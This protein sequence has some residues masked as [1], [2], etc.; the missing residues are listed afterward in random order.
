MGKHFALVAGAVMAG[1]TGAAQ[2][3]PVARV[4]GG[5][6]AGK[7]LP[8]VEAFLGIP[9]AAPPVG[10]SRWRAPQ[11]VLPWQGKRDATRFGPACAQGIAGAW[12]PYSAEFIAQP[13]VS[14]DCLTLNV[15]KPVKSN[16]KLPVFVYIHGGAFQGGAGSLPVYDGSALAARGAVVITI[17]YRVGV[18]GFFA[19]PELTAEAADRTSGNYGLQDQ[20]AAL[21]WVR[22][23]AV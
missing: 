17:N 20:L 11:P 12:G 18:F 7:S 13:P 5:Q 10:E 6:L 3:E 9:Y 16:G 2:A 21:R 15:W 19:H 1:L 23:N 14:E 22:T 4:T 8:G